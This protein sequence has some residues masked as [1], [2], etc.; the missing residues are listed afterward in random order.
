[1][2]RL[3]KGDIQQKIEDNYNTWCKHIGFDALE[4]LSA[5]EINT[6]IE[7]YDVKGKTVCVKRD[8]LM[9]DGVTLPPW[10]KLSALR[11]VLLDV[12]PSKTFDTFI[13]FWFMV[14]VG[15]IR[16]LKRVRI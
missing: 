16:T 15:I 11:N 9:G 13:S 14:W 2:Q 7:K 6:P 12:K 5:M 3:E 4:Q 8:D 10:G 1:M